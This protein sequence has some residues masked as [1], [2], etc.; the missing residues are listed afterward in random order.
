MMNA[1]FENCNNFKEERKSEKEYMR[2]EE[3][4][5]KRSI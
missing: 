5:K 4:V 3:G 1:K 2:L